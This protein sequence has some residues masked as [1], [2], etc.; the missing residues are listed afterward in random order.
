M[1]IIKNTTNHAR[2]S[3]NVA[4]HAMIDSPAGTGILRIL[5]GWFRR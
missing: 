1:R 2:A 4:D 3:F 5:R